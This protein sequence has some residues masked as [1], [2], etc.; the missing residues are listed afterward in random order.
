MSQRCCRS[1]L[2]GTQQLDLSSTRGNA[3]EKDQ[4]KHTRNQYEQQPRRHETCSLD[5][6][7]VTQRA[8]AVGPLRRPP[9][10]FWRAETM[11]K[12]TSKFRYAFA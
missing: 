1:S 6:C 9:P 12:H 11:A 2:V 8:K 4:V 5:T 7:D 3:K 10:C